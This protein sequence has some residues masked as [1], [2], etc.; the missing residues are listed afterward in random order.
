[1]LTATEAKQKSFNNVRNRYHRHPEYSSS[2]LVDSMLE[3]VENKINKGQGDMLTVYFFNANDTDDDKMI[4]WTTLKALGYYV[5]YS[6]S[7]LYAVISWKK[8][9]VNE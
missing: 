1:M 6:K 7:W 8:A 4:A 5:R 3:E 9:S 2:K